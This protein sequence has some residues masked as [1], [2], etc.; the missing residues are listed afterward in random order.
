MNKNLYSALINEINNEML[1]ITFNYN[2]NYLS[3]D[4]INK[5]EEKE[6]RDLSSSRYLKKLIKQ[7]LEYSDEIGNFITPDEIDILR[8]GEFN[9]S[10]LLYLYD[11]MTPYLESYIKL[12]DEF[13]SKISSTLDTKRLSSGYTG[14]FPLYMI[15]SENKL[16]L[17]RA[18]ILTNAKTVLS[19]QSKKFGFYVSYVDYD[20]KLDNYHLDGFDLR[21]RSINEIIDYVDKKSFKFDMNSSTYYE[22]DTIEFKENMEYS[23]GELSFFLDKKR[24]TFNGLK[25]AFKQSFKTVGISILILVVF[26][27]FYFL[28]RYFIRR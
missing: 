3:R 17:E 11:K 6:F 25:A 28:Y 14:K 8:K 26:L 23:L 4:I 2:A 19:K 21:D 18:Y 15:L 16:T 24:Q 27:V 5:F 1:F 7:F 20:I 12:L 10:N 22:T 9:K 13:G